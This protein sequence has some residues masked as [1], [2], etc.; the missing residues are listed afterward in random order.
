MHTARSPNFMLFS[1]A[2][3][4]TFP[5]YH[6]IQRRSHGFQERGGVPPDAKETLLSVSTFSCRL[7]QKSW[8]SFTM[9]VSLKGILTGLFKPPQ[10]EGVLTEGN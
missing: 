10:V 5:I 8:Y 3:G 6:C 2:A 4:A 1:A 9:L 7:V